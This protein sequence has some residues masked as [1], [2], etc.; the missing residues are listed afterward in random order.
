VSPSLA[1]ELFYK[2]SRKSMSFPAWPIGDYPV[3]VR[4]ASIPL[5][6]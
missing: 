1:P 6:V 5:A 3:V 4:R 2:G